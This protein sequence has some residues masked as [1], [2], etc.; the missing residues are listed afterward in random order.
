MQC[1]NLI[2]DRIQLGRDR[3]NLGHALVAPYRRHLDVRPQIEVNLKLA[4]DKARGVELCLETGLQQAVEAR[5]TYREVTVDQG[6][7]IW[8][9]I[10]I[11]RDACRHILGIKA[12]RY[13][14]HRAHLNTAEGHRSA[15]RQARDGTLKEHHRPEGMTEEMEA[16]KQQDRGNAQP[17]STQ[18]EAANKSWLNRCHPRL[19]SSGCCRGSLHDS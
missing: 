19:P 11:D 14:L 15:H 8:L 5:I 16:A 18:H 17:Q 2:F 6:Y 4:G 7:R 12:Q 3:R 1:R 9:Q 10:E 13:A